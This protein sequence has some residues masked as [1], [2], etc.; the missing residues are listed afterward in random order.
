MAFGRFGAGQCDQAGL[1]LPGD[2]GF[3]RRGQA[4]LA[5]DGIHGVTAAIGVHLADLHDCVRAD[6]GALG[7]HDM[8]R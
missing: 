2:F 1:D 5:C 6:S 3:H 8:G 7:D 4:L